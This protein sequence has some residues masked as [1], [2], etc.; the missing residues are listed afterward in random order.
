M[1]VLSFNELG[2]SLAVIRWRDDPATIAPT[3]NTIAVASSALLTVAVFVGAPWISA[4]L[5][6]VRAA[7]VVQVI[8]VSILLNGLVATSAAVM[9]R[10][11]MQKQRTIADQVNTWLGAGLSLLLVLLGWGAMSLAVGRLVAS[12]RL[13]RS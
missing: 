6:D 4:T 7:P 13:R 2:V 10:E 8:S 5:G 9:Q 3:I 11:F 12:R 1:A